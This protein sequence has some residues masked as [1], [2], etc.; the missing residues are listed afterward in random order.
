VDVTIFDVGGRT[1]RQQRL[2]ALAAGLH[3]WTWDGRDGHGRPIASGA[4]FARLTAGSST[5]TRKLLK[6]Q[7]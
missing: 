7:N 3:E 4:Y 2:G 5:Q 1:V 6:L